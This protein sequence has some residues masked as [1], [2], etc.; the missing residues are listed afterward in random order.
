[1]AAQTLAFKP[2]RGSAKA[3]LDHIYKV[4]FSKNV[5]LVMVLLFAVFAVWRSN[6]YIMASIGASAWISIPLAIC[7][8]TAML[9]S[10]AA[11][12]ISMRE[13]YIRELKDEDAQRARLGVYVSYVMLAVTTIALLLIAGADG[14]MESNGDI[15]F[16]ALMLL[17]Q[18]VQSCAILVF[19][20]IADLEEREIVREEYGNYQQQAAQ[21]NAN[22][23]PWCYKPLLINNRKRH[24][25][26]CPNR[27]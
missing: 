15:W 11:A 17:I 12:F 7:I 4:K 19:I 9:A 27:P 26:S 18:F 1:M 21:Q 8:E 3:L 22:Q 14:A 2:Q 10:G 16:V 24:M 25:D 20:N 6:H 5:P 13:A 23:C